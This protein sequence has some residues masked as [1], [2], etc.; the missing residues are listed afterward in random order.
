MLVCRP[1]DWIEFTFGFLIDGLSLRLVDFKYEHPKISS[2]AK[3]STFEHLS[4]YL[5]ENVDRYVVLARFDITRRKSPGFLVRF[6]RL[7]CYNQ[8]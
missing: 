5:V 2:T 3:V 1:D 6:I 4:R 7:S 8:R